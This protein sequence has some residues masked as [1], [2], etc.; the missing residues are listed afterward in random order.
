[1][2]LLMSTTVWA[3]KEEKEF[4]VHARTKY[5][6]QDVVEGTV[7]AKTGEHVVKLDDGK[8]EIRVNGIIDEAARLMVM[9]IRK[10]KKEIWAWL[11]S[12]TKEIG[13]NKSAYDIF[14]VD[15][16]GDRIEV[17]EGSQVSV[18]S[19]I[20]TQKV[21][22]YYITD[23]GQHNA[24]KAIIEAYV[25]KFNMIRNG[26]Y[27]LLVQNGKDQIGKDFEKGDE[28][29]DPKDEEDK[30]DD[31]EDEESEDEEESE[32][33]YDET[34]NEN[35]GEGLGKPGETSPEAAKADAMWLIIMFVIIAV[36]IVLFII[37]FAKKKKNKDDG[38]EKPK[39]EKKAKKSKKQKED[40]IIPEI[41]L[42]I[43]SEMRKDIPAEIPVEKP[44]NDGVEE[45]S[46]EDHF[47]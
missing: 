26:Y 17:G 12:I 13:E 21:A 6:V 18:I 27:T 7:D 45:I 31:K 37:I 16:K 32:L 10:D 2:I 30:E 24:L 39:K 20:K 8:L 28:K 34:D 44:H 9:P 5:G 42:D 19:N 33:P 47:K 41:D 1:M 15:E 22:V 46:V 38:Y 36:T 25:V 23:E 4:G 29:I 3:A 11:Q 14:F 35:D 40:D 43:I